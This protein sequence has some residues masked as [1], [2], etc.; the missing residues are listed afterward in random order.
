M[1]LYMLAGDST[2]IS[3]QEEYQGNSLSWKTSRSC[4]CD[5]VVF[6]TSSSFSFIWLIGYFL[7][8]ETCQTMISVV[9]FPHMAP[10]PSSLNKGNINCVCV[11]V[12]VITIMFVKMIFSFRNNPRVT[13]PE[14]MGFVRYDDIGGRC[15]WKND[16]PE[17]N[18]LVTR[19]FRVS[20]CNIDIYL[21]YNGNN[22]EYLFFPY[23]LL[24][25]SH[26]LI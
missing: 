21:M 22:I 11:C 12:K 18:L 7:C 6:I 25:F 23:P 8:A 16:N 1:M 13:G 20:I 3:W 15:K 19:W 9:P 4:E 24:L 17:P 26:G 2:T 5:S 10:S 14:L